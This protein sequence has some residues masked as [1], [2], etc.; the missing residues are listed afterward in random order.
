MKC[1][2]HAT[3]LQRPTGTVEP[4]EC[5]NRSQSDKI[6]QE[7]TTE[8]NGRRDKRRHLVMCE[9]QQERSTR[10]RSP[11]RNAKTK[12]QAPAPRRCC[13]EANEEVRHQSVR[14]PSTA[15][16]RRMCQLSRARQVGAERRR[17]DSP[18]TTPITI[19][20]LRKR[21]FI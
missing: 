2:K 15:S 1:A 13:N 16:A 21:D 9:S 14:A 7:Q 12:K 6:Q 3:K 17:H 4:A 10:E 20:D 19:I 5:G 8:T 18:Q 11:H